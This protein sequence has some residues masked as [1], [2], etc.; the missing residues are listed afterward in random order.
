MRLARAVR[1]AL[2]RRRDARRTRARGRQRVQ[3]RVRQPVPRHAGAEHVERL[4]VLRRSKIDTTAEAQGV[5]YAVFIVNQWKTGQPAKLEVDLGGAT[6]RRSSSSRASRSGPGPNIPY[7]PFDAANG[8]PQNQVAI[9]FFSR[10]P[11]GARATRTTTDPR[12]LANCPPASR[13][14]SSATRRSTGPASARRS[15]S[16]RTSRS[17]PT[18]CSRT[19]AAAR[20]SRGRR[21]SCRRTCGTRTTSRPTPTTTRRGIVRRGG[22][23]Q[24]PALARPWS[25]WPSRTT[26]TSPSTRSPTSWRARASRAPQRAHPI[27]YT[28]DQ[29]QYLQFTQTAS[30]RG[31]PSSPTS[32]SPSSA[33]RR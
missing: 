11:A 1:G 29:G 15:T 13:P 16:A 24:D 22:A 2:Q 7:T 31:A 9:L 26:R 18:R 25:S 3:G 19:A 23:Q 12:V 27:T 21:C 32:P 10:D 30:S 8:L 5:C 14:P 17:S 4:R 33:A 28:I 20:A 6:S